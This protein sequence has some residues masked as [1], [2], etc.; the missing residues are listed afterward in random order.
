M[1]IAELPSPIAVCAVCIMSVY[2]ASYLFSRAEIWFCLQQ[3]FAIAYTLL[4]FNFIFKSLR[5]V[6]IG[7]KLFILSAPVYYDFIRYVFI[8]SFDTY[9]I[10]I[11][12]WV[13]RDVNTVKTVNTV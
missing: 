6:S 5:A 10:L 8:F 2:S 1:E 7:S 12:Y 11:S 3:I 9:L 4:N 13:H